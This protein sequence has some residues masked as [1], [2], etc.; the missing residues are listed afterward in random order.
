VYYGVKPDLVCYGKVVG[1]G[2][3]IGAVV[4]DSSASRNSLSLSSDTHRSAQQYM[5]HTIV[6]EQ[7]TAYCQT[8]TVQSHRIYMS[9]DVV[10]HETSLTAGQRPLC[11]WWIWQGGRAAVME[12]FGAAVNGLFPTGATVA[13]AEEDPHD[14]T[15]SSQEQ[16]E[17]EELGAAAPELVA[18][19][20]VRGRKGVFGAIG[21]FNGSPLSM[22]AGVAALSNLR[23]RKDTV[24]PW[25]EAT[26]SAHCIAASLRGWYHPPRWVRTAHRT[27]SQ[28]PV[29]CSKSIETG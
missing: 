22:A 26:V 9:C 21:T 13:E 11:M 4:S 10:R 29:C 1:G 3:P 27:L 23:R 14:T 28:Y 20:G 5:A 17:A 2:M 8:H 18:G 15:S 6:R 7:H 25:L 12:R 19:A 24:Y 16:E